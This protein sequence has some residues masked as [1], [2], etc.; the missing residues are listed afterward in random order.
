[1]WE[2]DRAIRVRA[3]AGDIVLCS[4]ARHF[5]L[6]VPLSPQEYKW[7]LANCWGNLTNCWGVTC[8][9][10]ASRPE[11]VEIL[12]AASCYRKRDKLRQLYLREEHGNTW[13]EQ[14][15]NILLAV[16]FLD[17]MALTSTSASCLGWISRFNK[18]QLWIKVSILY[19]K[20]TN[21]SCIYPQGNSSEGSAVKGFCETQSGCKTYIA[22]TLLI[23]MVLFSVFI[24]AIANKTVVLR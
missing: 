16:F 20:F 6:T 13:T 14:H 22:F 21:C 2:A 7:V 18:K 12:L 15:I 23:V 9:G 24:T 3:L 10:L 1:M 5:T 11:G 17:P 8:D 4:W 19:Q